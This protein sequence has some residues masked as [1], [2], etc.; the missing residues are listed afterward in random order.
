MPDDPPVTRLMLITPELGEIDA[1]EASFEGAL[2]AGDVAAVVIRLAPADD[3][4]RLARA[5]TL[6][7]AAQAE[8]AAALLAGDGVEDIVGK[9]GADGLHVAD[10]AAALDA[11][12]RFKPEKIVGCGPLASRDDAMAAGEAGVDYVLFGEDVGGRP[13]D[14]TLERVAWWTPIFETPCVGFAQELDQ[15][16]ALAGENAEFALLGEAVW[17]HQSGPAVAVAEAGSMLSLAKAP[18]P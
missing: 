5:K 1:F 18:T 4:T 14:A 3:R 8:G 12:E 10:L 17:R 6:V 9:S 2:A 11:I 7:E 13:F 15:V 16:A